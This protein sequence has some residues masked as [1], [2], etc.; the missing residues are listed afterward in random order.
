MSRYFSCVIAIIIYN[1]FIMLSLFLITYCM[2]FMASRCSQRFIKTPLLPP[3]WSVS[4]FLNNTF[5]RYVAF[6]FNKTR[7]ILFWATTQVT[8]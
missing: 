5:N 3:A 4:F 2:I 8:N 7:Y 6:S 1:V